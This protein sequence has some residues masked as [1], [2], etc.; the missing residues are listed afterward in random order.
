ML[1][2]VLVIIVYIVILLLVS[3]FLPHNLKN[4]IVKDEL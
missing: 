2:I 1:T 4:Y 3:L